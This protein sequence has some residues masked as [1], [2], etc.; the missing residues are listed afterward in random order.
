MDKQLTAEQ[1]TIYQVFS[2]P[3]V[4]FLIPDYQRPY[5]WERE[6]CE[7]LWNDIKDFAFPNDNCDDFNDS[8]TYFLGTILTFP[9][10]SNEYEVIDGQQRL[11]TFLLLLRAFYDAFGKMQ[12]SNAKN[13]LM[14]LEECIWNTDRFGN[15]DQSSIKVISEVIIDTDNDELKKI[16]VEGKS[17]K[18]N[19]SNYAKNY[20]YFQE[21]IKGFIKRT[22]DYFSLLPL[23]ILNNCVL[24]PIRVDSRETALQI[25]T[26]LND[27][28]MPLSDTDIL[29]AKFYKFYS[30]DDE[31]KSNFIKDWKDLE[32]LCSKIFHPKKGISPLEELFTTYMYYLKAKEGSRTTSFKSLRKFY[33]QGDYKYLQD[34]TFEDLKSLADFWKNIYSRNY[35]RYSE[36]V[37]RQL[38][39]LEYS[40]Y[41]IWR[42]VVSAYFLV[43][44]KNMKR[45]DDKQFYKFLKRLTAFIL[46]Y[47]IYKP[48]VS[49]IRLPI[50][51]EI[52]NLYEKKPVE[53]KNFRFDITILTSKRKE[54]I[55][56]NPRLITRAMLAW[57]AFRDE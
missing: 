5:S 27:R 17:T 53:F 1:K 34:E 57:W 56:S 38:Y 35:N 23:R 41:A 29:K 44:G 26:T 30:T 52:V 13:V 40:P 3:R 20:C 18:G 39:I 24:L 47:S 22:P 32:E 49:S 46:A 11:V 45:E 19:K 15:P 51:N 28:G 9:N 36:R 50:H 16:T 8:D 48:G 10:F 42:H 55:F 2:A 6:Q 33:E 54:F 25:F 37:L 31:K 14:K 21:C 12:D 4:S 7:T 43:H